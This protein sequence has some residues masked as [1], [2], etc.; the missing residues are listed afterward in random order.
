VPPL[1]GLYTVPLP[2]IAYALFGTFAND[3]GS[4][5]DS[6]TALISY[7]VVGALAVSRIPTEYLV[8]DVRAGTAGGRV[9]PALWPAAD[10]L[11]GQLHFNPGHARFCYPGADVDDDHGPDPYAPGGSREA[12]AISLPKS[13]P[14]CR[15][16]I[17]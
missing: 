10:R 5:P 15:R 14:L 12:T 16:A 2:L 8:I 11:G 6:A 17:R 3:G 1:V 4:G 9:L 13:G 7:T